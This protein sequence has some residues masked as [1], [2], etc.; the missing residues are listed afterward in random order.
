MAG[1]LPGQPCSHPRSVNE[2]GTGEPHTY[3]PT[4]PLS[5]ATRIWWRAIHG[6]ASFVLIRTSFQLPSAQAHGPL[7]GRLTRAPSISLQP[8]YC[9]PHEL[10]GVMSGAALLC[11]WPNPG[12][13]CVAGISRVAFLE[14]SLSF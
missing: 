11:L 1:L 6:G 12:S 2:W 9:F 13:L 5:A 14:P 3:I 10:G 7:T 4:C 8:S